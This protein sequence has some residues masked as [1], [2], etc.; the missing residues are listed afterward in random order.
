MPQGSL[1]IVG[2]GIRLS[3]LSAEARGCIEGADKLLFLVSN[4][5]TYSWLTQV[6]SSAESL[7]TL[8]GADKLRQT[9]YEQMIERILS[10]VREGSNVCVA[11][12][13]HPGVFAYPGHEAMRRARL[14]GYSARMLPGI[15]A[16]DCLF[17]DLGI[18]PG[19]NGCQSFEATD[20]LISRR[21]F[22][23][24]SP[25]ILWQIAVAG[26]PGYRTECNANGLNILVDYLFQHYEKAHKVTVYEASCYL[27]SE[28]LIK[29]IALE[30]LPQ[31]EV[32]LSTTLYVP[33]K[34]PAIPDLA[35]AGRLGIP[36]SYFRRNSPGN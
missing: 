13:G 11:L 6:N 1:T 33:P 17:A 24:A 27:G 19:T 9:T 29:Q 15:S 28:P 7:H 34:G 16:E 23:T 21:R 2:T 5:V 31:A 25:L 22:D 12:Y 36:P 3:Q 30:E 35:M 32:T 26:D 10:F 18:D 4:A 8:Y 20:F 14:E